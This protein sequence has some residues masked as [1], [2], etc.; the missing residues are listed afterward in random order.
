M[1]IYPTD[2]E[3]NFRQSIKKYF[4]DNVY[5]TYGV[6]LLFNSMGDD[7]ADPNLINHTV[8]R[9]VSIVFGDYSNWNKMIRRYIEIYTCTR[10]DPE[11]YELAQLND[12]IINLLNE[13]TITDGM[14][15]IPF[16]NCV[17]ED[18]STWVE[19]GKMLVQRYTMSKDYD[20]QD[21]TNLVRF[22]VLLR[23]GTY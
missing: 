22:N 5:T 4:V 11:K 13:H 10:G 21:G 16:Y 6:K 1:S 2:K 23:W 12:I 14:K 19:I 3:V 9:W 20:L 15:R 18:S 7:V 8:D 17:S